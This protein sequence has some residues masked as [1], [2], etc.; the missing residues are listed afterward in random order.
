MT[1]PT[2]LPPIGRPA[3][4][5]L[6]EEGI[7]SLDDLRG[8]DIDELASLHGVGPKALRLLREVLDAPGAAGASGESG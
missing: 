2:P 4:R 3:T 1:D 6:A 7:N 5:A 8:R